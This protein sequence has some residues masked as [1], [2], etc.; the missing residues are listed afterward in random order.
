MRFFLSLIFLF[1]I[2][3]KLFGQADYTTSVT[4]PAGYAVGDYIEFVK[5]APID[6]GS[7][8]NYEISISYTRGNIAAAATHLASIS[9]SNP[10][11]WREAGRIND[12]PYTTA[13][14][15]NFT[16][17][18]NT[19]YTN[20]RFRIRAVNTLGVLTSALTV[21][22]KVHSNNS[23]S[24]WTALSATGNDLTVNTF[25]PMTDQWNLYFGNVF[26]S[27][28][29]K[30]AIRAVD[31]GYVGIGT[32]NPDQQLTVNGTIH[33]KAVLVDNNVHPDYVFDKSYDLPTLS[34][35][36]I[37]ID[38]N[39]HLPEIPS[40]AEVAKNGQNVGEMNALLLKKVEELTLYLIAKE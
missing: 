6:A 7:S 18:C 9:H 3:G 32:A 24:V 40:A 8:G 11:L 29:A 17:D 13:G 14:A 5:V 21:N 4:F 22:I 16:I 2:S 31:N 12:N 23:N 35:I 25:V 10:A 36:K 27:A 37:Y 38:K 15:Y 30:I 33:S 39:H 1:V 19:Q 20:P 28:G 26:S 34:A